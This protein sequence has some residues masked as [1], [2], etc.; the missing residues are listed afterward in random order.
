MFFTHIEYIP[1]M[2][3]GSQEREL[4]VMQAL[5]IGGAAR[6]LVRQALS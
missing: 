2:N 3:V 6:A 4:G 5:V 1:N